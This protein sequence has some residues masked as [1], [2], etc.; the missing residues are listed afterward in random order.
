MADLHRTAGEEP[1]ELRRKR[2]SGHCPAG[3]STKGQGPSTREAP[4]NNDQRAHME[5]RGYRL[6]DVLDPPGKSASEPTRRKNGQNAPRKGTAH[7]T[8]ATHG[9][10]IRAGRPQH[11]P[12]MGPPR[13][14]QNGTAPT[15]RDTAGEWATKPTGH[16]SPRG[17]SPNDGRPRRTLTHRNTVLFH[18]FFLIPQQHSA[19][20]KPKG[21]SARHVFGLRAALGGRLFLARWTAGAV[22]GPERQWTLPR[23]GALRTICP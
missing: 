19:A 21:K 4:S 8:S 16:R 23:K 1:A 7:R 5:L 3:E 6:G 17:T 14:R 2:T 13:Q 20:T 12:A 22:I 15:E 18:N 9:R 11:Q 10:Q